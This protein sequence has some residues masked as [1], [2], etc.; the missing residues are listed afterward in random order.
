VSRIVL[1]YG[2]S[3]R[4]PLHQKEKR[5]KEDAWLHARGRY[6]SLVVVCDGMG[7]RQHALL[8]ARAGCMAVREAVSKWAQ[9]EDAP[10]SYLALLT[11]VLWRL[12]IHP[13][14]QVT[15]PRPA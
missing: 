2:A 4:G 3:V 8:G 11:E 6:G 1:S 5:P 10:L 12:R 9:V 15:P 14:N 7:S 13:T